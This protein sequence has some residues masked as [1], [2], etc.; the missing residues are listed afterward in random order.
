MT[1]SRKI[2]HEPGAHARDHV[3]LL[4]RGELPRH[5]ASPSRRPG[6]PAR[7]AATRPALRGAGRAGADDRAGRGR[8]PGSP[9][10]GRDI[11]GRRAGSAPE[12][13]GDQATV[14]WSSGGAGC[15]GGVPACGSALLGRL[16]HVRL[17]SYRWIDREGG[18]LSD[19]GADLGEDGAHLSTQEDEGHD[20]ERSR[21]GAD[22]SRGPD[23]PPRGLS[24]PRSG[25]RPRCSRI[26]HGDLA[27]W[28][29]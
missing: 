3:A 13:P 26:G 25:E 29:S 11:A 19:R 12:A 27:S 5:R 1:E 21:A 22:R 15:S 24:S 23:T 6:L 8:A 7:A 18:G 2:G 28:D 17:L 9:A 16:R 10:G 14:G 4:A 20:R